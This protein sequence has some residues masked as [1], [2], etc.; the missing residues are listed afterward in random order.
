MLVFYRALC[1]YLGEEKFNALYE[2]DRFILRAHPFDTLTK[3]LFE[4]VSIQSSAEIQPGDQCCFKNLLAYFFKHGLHENTYVVST[5]DNNFI[6]LG[7]QSST[8]REVEEGCLDNI[9]SPPVSKDL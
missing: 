6:G 3:F 5:S 4:T 8:K 1:S 7:F 2:Q 9:M